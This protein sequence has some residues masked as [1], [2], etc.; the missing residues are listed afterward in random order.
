MKE[1][2]W[3]EAEASASPHSLLG[4]L[5]L[6][7]SFPGTLLLSE[8]FATRALHA[9]GLRRGLEGVC[10]ETTLGTDPAYEK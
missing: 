4:Q 9:E 8:P 5:P 6:A 1:S 10:V 7:F 3:G 2:R